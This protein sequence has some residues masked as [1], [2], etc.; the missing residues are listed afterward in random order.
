MTNKARIF[1]GIKIKINLGEGMDDYGIENVPYNTID[2]FISKESESHPLLWDTERGNINLL[3]S[4]LDLYK[5]V[6]C[7]PE[8]DP[9]ILMGFRKNSHSPDYYNGGKFLTLREIDRKIKN[10]FVV[11]VDGVGEIDSIDDII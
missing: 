1:K 11:A 3:E 7:K 10:G 8:G 9:Y 2:E 4:D 5:V 6:S